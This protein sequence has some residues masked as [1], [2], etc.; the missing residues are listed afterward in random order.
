M[1]QINILYVVREKKS[2]YNCVS[3]LKDSKGAVR[4]ILTGYNQPTKRKP[5]FT[6]KGITYNL[7][8]ED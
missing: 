6:L 4:K 5:F 2:T 7:K 1:Q 8:F 3:I